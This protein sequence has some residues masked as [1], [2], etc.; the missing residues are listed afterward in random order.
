LLEKESMIKI[1][2]IMQHYDM[3][4][5]EGKKFKN[6]ATQLQ[7]KLTQDINKS[8]LHF[9]SIRTEL[10]IAFSIPIILI[11][12]LGV[13]TYTRASNVI[14]NNYKTSAEQTLAANGNYIKLI[15]DNVEA[16]STQIVSNANISKYYAG[17]YEK[18][19]MEEFNA[20][21]GANQDLLATVGSDK[22]IYTINIICTEYNPIS[23]YAN[24]SGNEYKEYE[25]SEEVKAFIKSGQKVMWSGY[26]NFLDSILNISQ[27]KYAITLMR[28]LYNKA[29][30]PIGYVIIDIKSDS[31]QNVLEGID[32][33]DRGN[34]VFVSG[35]GRILTKSTEDDK[36]AILTNEIANEKFYTQS[37][38]DETE[39]GAK[40]V[41]YK[42]QKY[43]FLYS[44]ISDTGAILYSLIPEAVILDQV[45]NIKMIT[46]GIVILAVVIALS[47]C[48][49][50]SIGI[51]STIK[52]IVFGVKK[53]ATGDLSI[54]IKTKR[55]DEFGLLVESIS[56]MISGMKGLIEKTVQVT[57]AVRNSTQMVGE[58]ASAF[59]KSSKGMALS[60]GDIEKGSYQQACDAENC[61]LMMDDL[62]GKI[63]D[64]YENT[65]KIEYIADDTKAIVSNGM[66]TVNALE[67]RVKDTSNMASILTEEIA[68]LKKDASS[69]GDIIAVINYVADQTNLLSLNASIE[70]ARAGQAGR[71]FAV[72]AEEIKKLAD[73]SIA[74]SD[75]VNEN[76][77]KINSRANHMVEIAS[78]TTEVV[79]SQEKALSDTVS[80]FENIND[81]VDNLVK[82]L[83]KISEG[84]NTVEEVKNST[85]GSIES[86]SSIIEE[87]AAV[88]GEVN[89]T[90]QRQ[91]QLAEMLKEATNQLEMDSSILEEAVKIFTL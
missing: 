50:I 85:L 89:E 70:A 67:D 74:A 53:A 29:S 45:T 91:L 33:G 20:Y 6:R 41:I 27:D 24:F 22:F 87:A 52:N 56:D 54:A 10:M 4:T 73:Q 35:D 64:V 78:K 55:R 2:F 30:K 58:T 15:L 90:A 46:I 49:A 36:D 51:S 19:S 63:G 5:K 28:Y 32:F 38:Q 69:I 34:I 80:I 42:G 44:K 37:L 14:I 62:S 76:I 60:L 59:I 77:G 40:D 16:K 9:N 57:S 75:K 88:T 68:Y 82:H 21:D 23:T 12:I 25:N 84:V 61:L 31:I 86:I 13:I 79:L 39:N 43:L 66:R 65:G 17:G 8:K 11:V 26:H 72:V 7:F 71:G 3:S 81:K 83:S 48:T 1:M 47:I 18:N